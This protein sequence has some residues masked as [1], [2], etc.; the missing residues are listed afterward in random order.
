MAIQPQIPEML[1]GSPTDFRLFLSHVASHKSFAADLKL[2]L[3]L[4]GID[5]FVAHEGIE[6]GVAWLRK[7]EAACDALVGI[8]HRG[9]RTSDWCDQEVGI[10]IGRGRPVVPLKIEL[11][12][13][14]FFGAVQAVNASNR[15]PRVIAREIVDLL[16]HDKRTSAQIVAALVRQLADAHSYDQANSARPIARRRDA[17]LVDSDQLAILRE[18]QEANRQVGEA[19]GVRRSLEE[20]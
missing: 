5:A 7:I 8:L 10:V 3:T 6:P 17:D 1:R 19:W 13:Y 2:A 16:I 12:P 20:Y 14:G 18:A 15:E 9:V 4:Y 11:D